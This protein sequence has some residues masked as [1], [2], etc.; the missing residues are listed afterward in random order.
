M[1]LK[2]IVGLTL[3]LLIMNLYAFP[4]PA[5]ADTESS[6]QYN[7][8]NK[9][10]ND[11][12]NDIIFYIVIL[13][14]I[15]IIVV[16]TIKEK[17]TNKQTR[18]LGKKNQLVKEY[19]DDYKG[20]KELLE[21]LYPQFIKVQN[22]LMNYDYNTLKETCTED[23]YNKLKT[24]FDILKQKKYKNIMKDYTLNSYYITDI[25]AMDN[26]IVIEMY[27][28]VTYKDYVVNLESNKITRGSTNTRVN[29]KYDLSFVINR[30]LIEKTCPNC[31]RML[32]ENTCEY[33]KVKVDANKKYLLNKKSI[34]KK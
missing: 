32:K 17:K 13:V 21:V 22:A 29:N 20:E 28:D 4:I 27:L 3:I 19:F 16:T 30:N 7:V 25:Y 2:K 11:K 33:C 14:F 5:S 24:D 1:K 6:Y 9:I 23:L 10:D 18:K 26:I 31:G 15:G 12:E 34:S 8:A